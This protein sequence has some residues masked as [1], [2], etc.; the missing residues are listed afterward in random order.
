M[1]LERWWRSV[2]RWRFKIELIPGWTVARTPG[3]LQNEGFVGENRRNFARLGNGVLVVGR[4]TLGRSLGRA[5]QKDL[6][7]EWRG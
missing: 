6:L 7:V 3:L 2:R 1:L 4:R 5:W